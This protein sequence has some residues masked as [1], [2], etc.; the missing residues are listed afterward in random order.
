MNVADK[1]M[2]G[3]LGMEQLAAISMAS[4]F[5]YVTAVMVWPISIGSQAITSRRFG[6]LN[7]AAENEKEKLYSFTGQVM[8]NGIIT[9]AVLGVIGI[10]IYQCAPFV[11]S[12]LITDKALI[13]YSLSYLSIM[14]WVL[15]IIGISS[16]FTGFLGGIRKTQ[17][18]MIATL[19]PNLLNILLNYIFIYGKLGVSPMGIT[20]AALGTVIANGFAPIMLIIY[21][22]RSKSIRKYQVFHFKKL[23]ITMIK[24]IINFS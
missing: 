5:F 21:I 17:I 7:D 19:I 22:L 23:D 20:G 10:F 12:K 14:R 1:A 8:D 16:A 24:R 2:V 9:G 6:R 3:H 4:L 11:L 15:P 13:P 18:I